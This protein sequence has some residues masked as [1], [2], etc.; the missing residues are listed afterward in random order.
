MRI[1]VTPRAGL[2]VRDPNQ[3]ARGYLPAS[4]AWR[5]DSQAWRRLAA[6]GDVIVATD[7]PPPPDTPKGRSK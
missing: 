3:P 7:A 6:A 5:E 1:Y 4:G 2:Q